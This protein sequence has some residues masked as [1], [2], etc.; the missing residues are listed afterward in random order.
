MTCYITGRNWI[1]KVSS[2]PNEMMPI[3]QMGGVQ[4]DIAQMMAITQPKNVEDYSQHDYPVW[5]RP[6]KWLTRPSPGCARAW[7]PVLHHPSITLRDVPQQIRNQ[8]VDEPD[9]SPLA[10]C[11]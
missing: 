2:F 5:T 1:S 11:F 8:L 3:N 10:G 9:Q 7:L 6:R 4:Q